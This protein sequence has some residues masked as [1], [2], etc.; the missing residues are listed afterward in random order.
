MSE[1]NEWNILFITGQLPQDKDGNMLFIWDPE[2]QTRLV[3]SQIL[4][5]LQ[6]AWMS[7]EDVVKITIYVKWKENIK[8]IS[9]VRDALLKD[10]R[11]ASTLI[12]VLWFAREDSCVE[13]DAIAMR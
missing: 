8:I 4:E 2:K 3:F 7:Y 13:I 5:I 1:V 10:I 6:E 11:P 9:E 12:E